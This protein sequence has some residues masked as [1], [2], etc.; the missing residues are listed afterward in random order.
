[1]PL[2]LRP[3]RLLL[4]CGAVSATA[5]AQDVACD[6]GDVEVAQLSFTGN[7]AFASS[8]LANGVVTT[9]STWARRTLRMFGTRRCLDRGE[10][11]RDVVRLLIW[12]RNHGY[13]GVAVD[14][15]V[16]PLG[17]G[18]VAVRFAI[19]E[20]APVRIDSLR[21]VGLGGVADS[22]LI[23]AALPL[24]EGRAFDKYAMEAT[25]DTVQRRLRDNGYPAAVV[26][27]GY[28]A[29]AAERRA[30]LTYTIVPGVRTR[31]GAV[32]VEMAPREVGVAVHSTPEA[33]RAVADLEPGALWRQRDLERAKRALYATQAFALVA[34]EPDTQRRSADS[35]LGVTLR[36]TEG[37]QR[38]ART[39]AGW[40]S[41][42]CFRVSGEMVDYN[43]RGSASRLELRGR[44]S[45]IGIGRP[46]GG[47]EGLCP[48]ARDDIF[49]RDLNYYVGSTLALRP[50]GAALWSPALTLFSEKRSEFNAFLRDTRGGAALTLAS[51]GRAA[52]RQLSYNVEYGSTF[53]LPALFCAVFNACTDTDQRA[54]ERRQRLA[55]LGGAWSWQRTDNPGDPHRGFVLRTDLRHGSR[56]IGA[57][58]SLQFT[59]GTVDVATYRAVGTDVVLAARARA[60]VVWGRRDLLA[61][62]EGAYVPPQERLYGGGPN[63]VRGYRQNELGPAV[64]IPTAFDTVD[65]SGAVVRN[66]DLGDPARTYYLR[67]DATQVRQRTVPTG[68][69]AVI[70]G[71]IEARLKSPVLSQFLQWTVFADGGQ[72]LDRGVRAVAGASQ[73]RVTPGI[74][75]RV[76]SFIGFL[77]VDV[78]YNGYAR[79]AGA[80]YFDTPVAQGGQLLCVS[81]GNTRRVQAVVSTGSA[82]AQRVLV[83][84]AGPCPATFAPPAPT[85]LLRRLTLNLNLGQA[86]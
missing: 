67:A 30:S 14:T 12:Y 9:P 71:N 24:R 68:G 53:A 32:Q 85:G 84:D 22:A 72:V 48:Q 11:P 74:G 41:L 18:R 78:A 86:F 45:K 58:P 29:R 82:G 8:V 56:F 64:Y 69:N 46:L 39:G 21:F 2:S 54:L 36:A 28:D 10:F 47:A 61:I 25:R 80:A 17:P 37:P 16:T 35:T 40:G 42:D 49:S 57:D 60:G 50:L 26:F 38:S 81:P 1:M 19:T 83:Q 34:I 52:T 51:A 27:V 55:V 6:A 5:A 65:A 23:V 15:V 31:L 77:R 62:A 66:A 4:L 13:T 3:L 7:R 76:A 79:N 33:V 43:L 59:R 44:M 63:T 73:F 20:G 70:L 75:V